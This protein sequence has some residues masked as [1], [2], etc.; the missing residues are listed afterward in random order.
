MPSKEFFVKKSSKNALLQG[1]LFPEFRQ[2]EMAEVSN[3]ISPYTRAYRER[4]GEQPRDDVIRR[5]VR[6]L[7][8]LEGEFG[9]EKAARHFAHFLAWTPLRFFSIDSFA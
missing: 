7:R 9:P 2:Q 4:Y 6:I 1:F 3:W 5:M 8:R